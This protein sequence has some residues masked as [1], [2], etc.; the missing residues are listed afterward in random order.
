MPGCDHGSTSLAWTNTAIAEASF[1]RHTR[2][3]LSHHHLVAAL[4]QIERRRVANGTGADN[5]NTHFALP[6]VSL[7]S[8]V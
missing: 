4:M 3:P 1:Q 5:H 7:F 6:L 2:L 8:A